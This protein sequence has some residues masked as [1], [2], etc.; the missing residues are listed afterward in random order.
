MMGKVFYNSSGALWIL[1]PTINSNESKTRYYIYALVCPIDNIIRYV[2]CTKHNLRN[3][4]C[5]HITEAKYNHPQNKKNDWIRE[6]LSMGMKPKIKMLFKTSDKK[7]AAK[8]EIVFILSNPAAY[9][10]SI[11]PY[12]N[13]KP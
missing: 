6:L 12:C 3:R 11:K 1:P 5:G 2:G 7:E 13:L 4:R 10:Q 8:K 9:N